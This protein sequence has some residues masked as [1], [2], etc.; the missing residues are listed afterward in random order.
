VLR[1]TT[2][3]AGAGHVLSIG[4]DNFTF[5]FFINCS[6][7][8]LWYDHACGSPRVLLENP[9]FFDPGPR[10]QK[11]TPDLLVVRKQ[12]SHPSDLR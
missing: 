9:P 10:V 5:V 12:R 4:G 8:D 11:P 6:L 1:Q 7:S 3:D 2:G